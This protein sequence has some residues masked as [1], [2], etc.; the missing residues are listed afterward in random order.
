M[1]KLRRLTYLGHSTL[2]IEM[3]GLRILTDPL[4]RARVTFLLRASPPVDPQLY[5]N[6]DLVLIS[7]LHYDHLDIPSLRLLGRQIKLVVPN[8]AAPVLRRAGFDNLVELRAGD[9]HSLNPVAIQAVFADHAR[10]RGPFG[11][12]AD[13]LGYLIR[14][15]ASAYFPG[16]TRLFSGMAN[17]A[18]ALD[19]ALIPV[20][21]WGYAPGVKHMTPRQ[22]AESLRLLRPRLAVPIHWG[23]Y[24]P[25]G[26]A[27]FNPAFLRFPPHDFIMHARQ[28]APQVQ[29][30]IL[31]PGESLEF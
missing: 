19:L 13:C 24:A 5:Q 31:L 26:I 27:Q 14:G 17:L 2:L 22:A 12:Q 21:G 3:D 6:I 30:R 18:D 11:A 1:T 16:D 20:W 9:I 29:T 4:L 25:L 23:S 15:S 10:S 8:G 28:S 7:H